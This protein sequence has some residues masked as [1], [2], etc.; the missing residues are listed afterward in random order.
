VA[1]A[2]VHPGDV[3]VGAEREQP[4]DP[5][6]VVDRE[7]EAGDAAVAPADDRGPPEPEVVHQ[8]DHVLGHPVV[9]DAVLRRGA[10]ALAP[11]VDHDDPVRAGER[12]DLVGPVRA[13]AEPAVQQD[14]RV[15]LVVVLAED[16]VV[17][18]EVV[19]REVA[20][21]VGRGQG[22]RL[23]QAL[24]ARPGRR[25]RAGDDHAPGHGEQR[26]RAG[27]TRPGRHR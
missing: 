19:D 22:R 25:P 2:R 13:V 20:G 23:G 18:R 12:A 26:Q 1:A 15:A 6:G 4:G 10:P 3:V 24:P 7:V 11:A 5:V 17:E 9:A 21:G 8:R 14:D 27:P 16:G